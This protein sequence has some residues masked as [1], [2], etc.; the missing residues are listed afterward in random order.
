MRRHAEDMRSAI[1]SVQTGLTEE[2]IDQYKVRLVASFNEAQSA[3]EAYRAHLRE[4]GILP[5]IPTTQ[6]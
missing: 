3:W 1:S 6:L 5:V 2:E 4:H